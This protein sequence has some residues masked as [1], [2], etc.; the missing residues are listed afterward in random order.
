MS[1]LANAFVRGVQQYLPSP[2]TIAFLLTGFTIFLALVFTTAKGRRFLFIR[3][4]FVLGRR[5]F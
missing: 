5:F 1:R 4:I 2:L 3:A